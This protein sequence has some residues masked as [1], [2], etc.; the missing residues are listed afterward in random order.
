[1]SH[2]RETRAASDSGETPDGLGLATHLSIER[3]PVNIKPLTKF[4]PLPLHLVIRLTLRMLR[5]AIE[6][7]TPGRGPSAGWQFAHSLAGTLRIELGV[8][9]VPF[10]KGNFIDQHCHSIGAKSH[11]I[12][13][14]LRFLMPAPLATAYKRGR[15]LLRGVTA[16]PNRAA[17][18]PP[19]E[20]H[21]LQADARAFVSLIQESFPW[22]SISTQRHVLISHS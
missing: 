9:S 18:I 4:M 21:R 1:M 14:I 19:A 13:R 20:Q 11:A 3:P 2:L 15:V 16:T 12:E 8:K 5:I 17:V 7:L 10:R 6:A 22:V